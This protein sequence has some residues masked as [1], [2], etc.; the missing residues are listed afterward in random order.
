MAPVARHCY[1]AMMK[2]T[3]IKCLAELVQEKH[4]EAMWQRIMDDAGVPRHTLI[5]AIGDIDDAQALALF[6]STT[7][8]LGL[9]PEQAADAFGAHWCCVY[10][11]RVYARTLQRFS[12][13]RELILGLDQ[14]H[15]D[16]TRSVANAAPP[17]FTYVW[18]SSNVLEV[19][20]VSHRGLIDIYVGLARGVGLMFKEALQVRKVSNTLVEITFS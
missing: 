14:I 5:L 12:N 16:V 4:G 17:R 6:S 20:Y 19:T 3:I 11:P 15:V 18:K 7:R 9:T 10:A 1:V 2:G 8:V 13:A